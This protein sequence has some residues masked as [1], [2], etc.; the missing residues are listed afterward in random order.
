[1]CS[2]D[3]AA[4]DIVAGCVRRVPRLRPLDAGTLSSAPAIESFTAVLLH[5]NAR[6]RTRVGIKLTGIDEP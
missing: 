6:Y 1:V 5:L 2:D 4:F 3:P